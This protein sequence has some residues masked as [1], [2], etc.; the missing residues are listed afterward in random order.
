[1]TARIAPVQPPLTLFQRFAYWITRRQYGV[2][3]TP[4]QVIYARKPRFA[5]LAQHIG[6]TLD[7]GL[8]LDDDL[9]VLATSRVAQVN[10]CAFCQDFALAK[11]IQKRLGADRFAALAD[12]AASLLFSERERAALA[13]CERASREHAVDDETFEK[14]RAHFSETEVIELAWIAAAETYFNIQAG[15]LRLGSDGLAER[16]AEAHGVTSRLLPDA[17]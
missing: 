9:V 1:M 15:V 7:G 11:S 17:A 12:Y 8:S 16:A 10:G 2:V 5:F 3:L 6:S 4:M 14:V 13:F